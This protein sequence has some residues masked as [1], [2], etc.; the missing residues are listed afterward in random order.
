MTV[1]RGRPTPE[2]KAATMR[3]TR[4]EARLINLLRRIDIGSKDVLKILLEKF[5][6]W[7]P[8]W[9]ADSVMRR[10]L[11]DWIEVIKKELEGGADEQGH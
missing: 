3:L 2:I 5:Q 11:V 6:G 4:G 1:K 10:K 7:L 8:S 9:E